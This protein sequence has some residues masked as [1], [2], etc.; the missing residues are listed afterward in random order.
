[1]MRDLVSRLAENQVIGP[2]TL[3][4]DNTPSAIDLAGFNSA[5]ILISVGAGGITFTTTNKIEF[6]V[7]HS[8]D[9]TTYTNVTDADVQGVSGISSG[10]VRSLTAAKAAADTAPTEIGY[11]GGKRYLKVLADFS[12]THATGTPV[13]VVLVKGNGVYKPS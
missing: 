6:V 11:I 3:S 5:M 4:A 9:D 2:V 12:G 10:I 8:D 13:S 1:M 7:T